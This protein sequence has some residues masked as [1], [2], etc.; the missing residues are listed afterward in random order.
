MLES[1]GIHSWADF[2]EGGDKLKPGPSGTDSL[3]FALA[4]VAETTYDGT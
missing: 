1:G 3:L 2:E 4:I